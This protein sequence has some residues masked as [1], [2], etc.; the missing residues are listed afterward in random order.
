MI[1]WPTM[2]TAYLAPVTAVQVGS[3]FVGKYYQILQQQPSLVHQFYTDLSTSVRVN[4]GSSETTACGMLQIHKLIMS[5]NFSGIE[6]KTAHSLESWSGGILVMVSGSALTEQSNGWRKF[7]QTFFLAPQENGYFILNDIFHLHE[8][9]QVHHQEQAPISVHSDYTPVTND[10]ASASQ[11]VGNYMHTREAHMNEFPVPADVEESEPF[12]KYNMSE[13]QTQGFP[14]ADDGGEDEPSAEEIADSN[15]QDQKAPPEEPSGDLT[16]HTYASILRVPKVAGGYASA[17]P[18]STVRASSILHEVEHQPQ[19]VREKSG[20]SPDDFGGHE[21]EG[22]VKSVY[23]RNLPST[24]S[25]TELEREFK[26]FGR[27][28]P[29]GVLIKTRKEAGV[30][31]AFVEFEDMVGVQNALKA[32]PILFGGRQIYVEERRPGSGT[33]RGRRVRVRGGHQAEAPLKGRAGSNGRAK[34][35]GYHRQDRGILGPQAGLKNGPKNA[36]DGSSY[37]PTQF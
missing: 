4:G 1:G 7:S 30:Y 12:D 11:S 16:R 23:V 8:E 37:A 32:S 14:E 20:G 21:D 10:S 24:V 15:Y 28:K 27:I 5:L 26:N 33:A 13:P 35:N 2:A 25:A 18:T 17:P 3:Y 22:E 31:Y 6:I 9:E 34:G 29:D 36:A 19:P